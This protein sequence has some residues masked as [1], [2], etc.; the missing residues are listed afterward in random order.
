MKKD[1]KYIFQVKKWKLL[2]YAKSF[3]FWLLGISGAFLVVCL[4]G[5]SDPQNGNVVDVYRRD[6]TQ[7]AKTNF[8]KNAEE[9]K[10]AKILFLGDVMF[11]RHIRTLTEKHGGDYNFILS[12]IKDI[13]ASYDLAVGNLEGP[14]TDKKS[15]S[16]GTGMTEKKNFIFSFDPAVANTLSE[17][18]IRL[19][20]LGNNHILNQGEEGLAETKKYLDGAGVE[21]FGDTGDGENDSIIRNVG[22]VKVGFVNYNYSA[23]GSFENAVEE[24]KEVKSESKVVIVCPHWGTEYK[25]GDPGQKIKALAYKF[26]DA[27]ADLVVGTHPHV[28]Q[29]SETYKGR[30]IYYSLGNFVFDQYFSPG[31]MRGLA[32][33]VEINPESFGMKFKELPVVMERNGKTTMDKE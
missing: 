20:N 27:G 15:V 26:I 18:N 17:N 13:L 11:D 23:A 22:G 24:I 9:K 1:S 3:H 8:E 31:T 32:I 25:T 10:S 12:D 5:C 29:T 21:Y 2:A 30:K 4:S 19:V 14:I 16:V 6:A 33:E 7:T 28:V